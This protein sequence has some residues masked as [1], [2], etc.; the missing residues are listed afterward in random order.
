MRFGNG[1][2]FCPDFGICP[3]EF[4]LDE[5]I[6]EAPLHWKKPQV[7]AVQ[8]LG[9]LFHEQIPDELIMKIL[10]KIERSCNPPGWPEK[11]YKYQFKNGDWMSHIFLLLTKRPKRMAD[12]WSKFLDEFSR[13]GIAPNINNL[14]LGAS[15]CN[16]QEADEK[17]PILLQIP[18]AHRFVNLGPM[19]ENISLKFTGCPNCGQSKQCWFPNYTICKAC[20][21]EVKSPPDSLDWVTLECESGPGRRPMKLEWARS[22]AEQCE[23]AGVP[24]F[25]KQLPINGRVSHDPTEWPEYLRIRQWPFSL[26][27]WI[28]SDTSKL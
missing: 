17:I 16:Q 24:L 1:N 13:Q 21:K 22:I 15:I 10:D 9:D 20:G 6:L 4:E 5:T 18:A 27:N 14:W 26:E 2:E 12:I 23:S 25:I 11:V 8:W 19:L 7:I 3:E 28:N